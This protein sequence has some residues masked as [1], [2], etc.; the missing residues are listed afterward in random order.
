M[1]V[2]TLDTLQAVAIVWAVSAARFRSEEYT[3]TGLASL[4][5]RRATLDDSTNSKFR[6]FDNGIPSSD[7]TPN[8]NPVSLFEMFW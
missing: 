3:A 8:Y 4:A 2:L 5:N 1:H 6:F 7:K